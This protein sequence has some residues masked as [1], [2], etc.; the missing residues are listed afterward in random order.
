ML[1]EEQECEL[2]ELEDLRR[3]VQ[4]LLLCSEIELLCYTCCR[5]EGRSTEV[6]AMLALSL[7]HLRESNSALF[8]D[9]AATTSMSVLAIT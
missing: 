3:L 5:V 9:V 6:P 8:W 4:I 7:S 2:L 1:L